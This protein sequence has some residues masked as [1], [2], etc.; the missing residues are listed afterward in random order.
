MNII[1]VLRYLLAAFLA[2]AMFSAHAGGKGYLGINIKVEG[3]G[4]FWNPTLKSVK[5]AN[6]V[7]GSPAERAG[8]TSGDLIVEV[9]GKQVLGAKTNELQPYMHREAGEQV[10]LVVKKPSGEVKPV[11]VVAGSMPE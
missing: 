9:E 2:A 3:E 11:S 8:I 5:V 10:K 4:A 1:A 7:P 6:V